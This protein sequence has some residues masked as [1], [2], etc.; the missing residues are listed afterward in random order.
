M[1]SEFFLSGL[2]YLECAIR[3]DGAK[4]YNNNENR[5]CIH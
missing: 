1:P 5:D 4:K 2:S 3:K